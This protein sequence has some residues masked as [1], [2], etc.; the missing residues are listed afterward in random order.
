[1]KMNNVVLLV[2]PSGTGKTTIAQIA[3]EKFGKRQVVSHTTRPK[4][5]PE[6][7]G[8]YFVSQEEFDRLRDELV[9]YTKFCGYEYGASQKVVDE[10]DLYVIDPEGVRYFLSSY[11][12]EKTPVVVLLSADEKTCA[13]RMLGRG[14]SQQDVDSRLRHDRGAF[15]DTGFNCMTAH[16][17]VSRM[18]A[19]IAAEVIVRMFLTD[20][21]LAKTEMSAEAAKHIRRLTKQ[22]YSKGNRIKLLEMVDD[23][24][25]AKPGS[26]ATI[27]RID[28]MGQLWCIWDDISCGLAVIPG[29]DMFN[30][31]PGSA[32]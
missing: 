22:V 16:L 20:S 1:M 10:S 8:H 11:T 5:L 4:R 21:R 14:D 7:Q 25:P 30:V 6:E 3:E 32:Q 9:A 23:Y 28:D 19:D 12:G 27:E 24:A 31:L 15:R 29:V 18:S 26:T 13:E 17:D 2:G